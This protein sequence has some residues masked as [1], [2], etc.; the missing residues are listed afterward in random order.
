MDGLP[1]TL[2]P[3][4]IVQISFNGSYGQWPLEDFVAS[5]F[6]MLHCCV[7]LGVSDDLVYECSCSTVV[8]RL[9]EEGKIVFTPHSFV[10]CRG[11]V[12]STMLRLRKYLER[13]FHW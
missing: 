1:G 6:D 10:D 11:G 5:G 13:G 3:I 7:S 12:D 8:Q 9:I 2:V 4:N